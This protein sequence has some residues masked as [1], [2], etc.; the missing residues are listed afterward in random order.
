MKQTTAKFE[1]LFFMRSRVSDLSAGSP[2]SLRGG[3]EPV[4]NGPGGNAKP[5]K[6]CIIPLAPIS[7]RPLTVQ[8]PITSLYRNAYIL[9]NTNRKV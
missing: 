9:I 8:S 5:N 4:S 7:F 3:A 2:V 1:V 6:D